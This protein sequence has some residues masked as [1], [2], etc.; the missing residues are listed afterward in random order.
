MPHMCQALELQIKNITKM[1]QNDTK[2]VT[3]MFHMCRVLQLA[4][5]RDKD[6]TCDMY[7]AGNSNGQHLGCYTCDE[8]LNLYV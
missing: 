1:L 5:L 6:A 7:Q 2:N 3:N 4:F 8:A